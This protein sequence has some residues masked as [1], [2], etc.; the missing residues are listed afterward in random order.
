MSPRLRCGQPRQAAGAPLPVRAPAGSVKGT[1]I[2]LALLAP[3]LSGCDDLLG[4]GGP[5]IHVSGEVR[6]ASD[7]SPVAGARVVAYTN[8]T[9]EWKQ[10]QRVAR[11]TPAHGRYSMTLDCPKGEKISV[12]ILYE[13]GRSPLGEPGR[14][15][16]VLHAVTRDGQPAPIGVEERN[17]PCTTDRRWTIDFHVKAAF[18]PPGEVAGGHHFGQI[19]AG[20][21]A[22]CGVTLDGRGYCWGNGAPG[23]G[24]Y[25]AYGQPGSTPVLV[26]GGHRFTA[27]T[28]GSD[29]ACGITA[30]H[31]ALCWGGYH[32]RATG[33]G[34]PAGS[35]RLVP[36][37]VS[38]NHRFHA[39]SAGA[40]HACALNTD[41]EAFCWGADDEGQLGRGAAGH[42]SPMPVAVTGGHRFASIVAGGLHT[43]ALT[44]QG[45]AY[46]WGNGAA[47][48]AQ[49]SASSATPI[50]V[51]GGHAFVRLSSGSHHTCGITTA[52]QAFCWGSNAVGQLGNGNPPHGGGVPVAVAGSRVFTTLSTG[53]EH[54]CAVTPAGELFC[55]GSN[56]SQQFGIAHPVSSSIPVAAHGLTLSSVAAG[57]A[58]PGSGFT[59]GLTAGDRAYCWG[60]NQATLGVAP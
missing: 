21:S 43:C 56:A 5:T 7:G 13:S 22:V 38:G 59:C 18:R 27:V 52:A 54:T 24:R 20:R 32:T 36:S 58:G 17:L 37:R 39:V 25:F 31:E 34:G 49:R 1:G 29:L 26:A 3:L 48:G 23:D 19:S 12:V 57:H 55:W 4:L 33:D 28:V 8:I 6:M 45:A 53:Y 40:D 47:L 9:G 50:R 15:D 14:D 42:P 46:C 41:G 44:S 30:D 60:A 51:S 2:A 16:L 35:P 11:V 10:L